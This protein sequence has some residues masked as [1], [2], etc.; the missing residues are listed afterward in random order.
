M[1][2][3]SKMRS[4]KMITRVRTRGHNV[5]PFCSCRTPYMESAFP[6]YDTHIANVKE[7]ILE[8]VFHKRRL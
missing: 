7:Q 3:F 1:R 4:S 8:G 2:P 5:E 6:E